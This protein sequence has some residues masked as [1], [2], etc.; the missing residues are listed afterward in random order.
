MKR[1]DN[2]LVTICIPSTKNSEQ[3]SFNV[4]LSDLQML[5]RNAIKENLK[6]LK[7][8]FG[9]LSIKQ[10]RHIILLAQKQYSSYNLIPKYLNNYLTCNST[11]ITEKILGR[12]QEIDRIWTYLASIQK[13]NAILI[14]QNGVGKTSI[15]TEIIRQ[16]NLGEC[17]KQ[18]RK[19]HVITLNTV[20]LLNLAELIELSEKYEI[21]YLKV[22]QQLDEFI[23]LHKENMILYIDNLLHVKCDLT[24]LKL[25]RKWLFE[26][27]IKFIASINTKDF[28]NY[29]EID[30]EIMRYLNNLWIV[31]P[32]VEE[33]YP[34]ISAKIA[35]MQNI[36]GVTISE[37]MIRFAIS[38]AEFHAQFNRAN[39][40]KTI[41]AINFALADAKKNSQKEVLKKNF[42]SYY[43]IDFRTANKTHKEREKI[44]SHHE[45]G[46]YLVGRLS[47]NLKSIK[48]DSV[49][50]LPSEEYGGVTVS[51]FDTTQYLS[52]S[53]EFFIDYIAYDLGGRVGEM[54][55]TKEFSSGASSDLV[56]AN[57]LA[58]QAVLSLGLTG[59]DNEKNKTYVAMGYVKDYLLTDEIKTKINQE[60]AKLMSEAYERAQKIINDNKE[61]FEEIVQR[62][63]EDKF[64]VSEE[65]EEICKKYIS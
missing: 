52:E 46:H 21:R 7:F 11:T 31:E 13:S 37:K 47:P 59:I 36:Y 58:E 6:V 24:I 8:S 15:A 23:K 14:G 20:N 19:Y 54:F 56:S 41:D 1:K 30:D 16:I 28:E 53:R 42:F 48:I 3:V 61:L 4:A 22:I 65:L 26:Y 35:A 63:L 45:A 49:S 64:L 55:Y 32:D 50:I 38:T 62:L 60:I 39:P 9:E 25:F 18:F 33:I 34:M 57:N 40:E 51:H 12:E 2:R 17:P 44:V 43:K 5:Y 27:N 10:L 29:F